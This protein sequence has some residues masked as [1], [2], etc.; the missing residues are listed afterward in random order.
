M[1]YFRHPDS[2]S[3]H[4]IMREIFKAC[5]GRKLVKSEEM[6]GMESSPD[7]TIAVLRAGRYLF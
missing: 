1:I 3:G 2:G 4:V 7:G 6:A 5:S